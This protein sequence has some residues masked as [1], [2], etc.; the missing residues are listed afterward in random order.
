[1][2]DQATPVSNQEN[3]SSMQLQCPNCNTTLPVT[4]EVQPKFCSNCGSSLSTVTGVSHLN[5]GETITVQPRSSSTAPVLYEASSNA[6]TQIGPFMIGDQLGQGGMGVVYSATHKETG[7]SVAVKILPGHIYSDELIQRFKREGQIAASIS[8]PRSTFIYEAG[9]HDGQLYIA[10]ELMGGG[11]LKDVIREKGPLPVNQ[12]VDFTLDII[13][14]LQ[15]AHRVGVIHRDL[16]PSNC[17]VDEDGRVKIGDYGLSKSVIADNAGLTQTGAFMGTPQFAAPEQIKNSQLDERT[18]IYAIGCTLFYLLTGQPPFSGNAAQVIASI[19]SDRAPRLIALDKE[20][21]RALDRIV[22]Q[23]LEKDPEKRPLNLLEL[24]EALLPFSSSG[25]SMANLGRRLAAFFVDITIAGFAANLIGSIATLFVVFSSNISS[26]SN[27]LL[28]S[29][30]TAGSFQVFGVI[31]YFTLLEHRFGKTIGKWLMGLRVIQKNSE[32]PK[33]TQ[34]LLRSSLLP[35][36]TWFVSHFPPVFWNM[37]TEAE[38]G[39]TTIN[40]FLMHSQVFTTLSWIPMLLCFTTMRKRNRLRGIHE[41]ASGT[42]TVELAGSMVEKQLDRIPVTIPVVTR[43]GQKGRFSVQGLLGRTKHG[44]VLAGQDTQL[45]RNVW[46]FSGCQLID[47][48]REKLK[49]REELSRPARLRMLHYELDDRDELLVFEAIRGAPLQS[50]LKNRRKTQWQNVRGLLSDLAT[51]LKQ[52]VEDNTLPT[53]LTPEQI[54][55]TESG[56]LKLLDCPIHTTISSEEEPSSNPH[57]E[58]RALQLLQQVM[59]DMIGRIVVP[60]HTIDFFHELET[61][62]QNLA[63]L[64][65]TCETFRGSSDMPSKWKWDDRTAV[66]AS[67]IGIELSAMYTMLVIS[68][69]ALFW[70]A[71]KSMTVG[72]ILVGLL[73]CAAFVWMG[74]HFQGSLVF[75][76][77]G[78]ELRTRD[79]RKASRLRCAIRAAIVWCPLAF[80]CY[81]SVMMQ[82]NFSAQQAQPS[83]SIGFLLVLGLISLVVS[84]IVSI[85]ALF[86]I[87][88]PMRG[89]QDFLVGTVLVRK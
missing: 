83:T 69:M 63:T 38:K 43:P 8:H 20:I 56:E 65:W 54:W 2:P 9:E 61:R 19:A 13:D 25:A 53:V 50:V 7:R 87:A 78:V 21:P 88:N 49:Q 1:M 15:A 79:L 37:A 10:M 36:L 11:T 73:S 24:R 89:L 45:E 86:A 28:F 17:F 5:V 74:H 71:P 66:M 58:T 3:R 76:L 67:T 42:Q 75:R 33:F 26:D 77:T 80:A 41:I 52:A 82:V 12:A 62:E 35:G 51:E 23:S 22:G 32:H 47:G 46:L 81:G 16:K 84:I 68:G 55:V 31:A 85:G 40:E 70:L 6:P 57:P 60:G 48:D 59:H 4:G 27:R 64:Q 34:S 72:L 44:V 29:Q 30:I 18:D 39:A 14:G